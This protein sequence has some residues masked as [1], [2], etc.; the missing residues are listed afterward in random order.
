[1]SS[2]TNTES[3]PIIGFS[4]GDING[5]GPE[6]IIKSLSDNRML[7]FFTP[8]VFASNKVINFYRK[9]LSEI[10]F[11]FSSIKDFNKI[12]PKQ[13]NI[14]NCWEEEIAIT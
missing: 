12:N 8:V 7:E 11:N 9:I 10:N 6:L 4:C 3:K 5:I 1:M 14:Y 13:V 2:T